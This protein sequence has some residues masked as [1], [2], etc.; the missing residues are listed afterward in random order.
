[1]ANIW[2]L[3]A[4]YKHLQTAL[5]CDPDDE[6]LTALLAEVKDDIKAKADGY[7]KIIKNFEAEVD[8]L[9]AEIDRL[10][11][12]RNSRKNSIKRLKENLMY[13]M[14]ETGETKFKTDLFSFGVQKVGGKEPLELTV[15]PEELPD[16]LRRVE[17]KPNNDAIREYIISTGDLSYGVIKERGET[18]RI[19]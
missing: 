2:D 15:S 14:K 4:Q 18:I 12:R 17:Y 1:M 6:E 8:G 7:A 10:T 9:D 3:T 5:E 13:S 16:E 19:R 11:K